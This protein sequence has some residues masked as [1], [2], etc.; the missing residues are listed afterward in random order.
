[1]KTLTPWFVLFLLMGCSG[2]IEPDVTRLCPPDHDAEAPP[3][4]AGEPPVE[5]DS[6]TPQPRRDAGMPQS[7]AASPPP[8]DAAVYDIPDGGWCHLPRASSTYSYED[9]C[10]LA[11]VWLPAECRPL[12]CPFSR[13]L[14][15]DGDPMN[16]SNHRVHGCH[17]LL[18]LAR[19]DCGVIARMYA[20]CGLC[21]E[22]DPL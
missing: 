9:A 14:D 2:V 19:D 11:N 7:D 4:D 21:Q 16:I 3:M 15:A 18:A 5:L 12:P 13:I 10:T 17:S 8:L 1:M 22:R 6:G 20:D